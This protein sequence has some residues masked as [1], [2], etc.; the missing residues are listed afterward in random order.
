MSAN[1]ILVVEDDTAIRELLCINLQV[2]GY[3][4]EAQADGDSVVCKLFFNETSSDETNDKTSLET[5]PS[6]Q[7][8]IDWLNGTFMIQAG[9][10]SRKI[11]AK[12]CGIMAKKQTAGTEQLPTALIS[13]YS[14]REL[15]RQS[16]HAVEYSGIKVRILNSGCA[17]AVSA[18]AAKLGVAVTTADTTSITLQTRWDGEEKERSYLI[19]IG[20]I[21]L[22]FS[23]SFVLA[24]HKIALLEQADYFSFLKQ[25]CTE[26]I[27]FARV[28]RMQAA[29]FFLLGSLIGFVAAVALPYFLPQGV[30]GTSVFMLHIL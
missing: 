1:R 25:P 9:K 20:F 30:Q 23:V 10:G 15:L 5:A 22:L 11:T 3:D 28:F 12:V 14:G 7:P 18:E 16:N 19:V 26:K 8:A 21:C 2:A 29:T 13:L 27:D 6:A 17:S 4:Y 24:L